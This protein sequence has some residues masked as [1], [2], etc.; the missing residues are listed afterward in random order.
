M[1]QIVVYGPGEDVYCAVSGTFM[2]V[3]QQYMSGLPI[4]PDPELNV[5]VQDREKTTNFHHAMGPFITRKDI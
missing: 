1:W 5:I 4:C 3:L 2:S